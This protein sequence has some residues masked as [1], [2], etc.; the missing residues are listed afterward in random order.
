MCGLTDQNNMCKAATN[1]LHSGEVVG[2]FFLNTGFS[3]LNFSTI[4]MVSIFVASY[5]SDTSAFKV[6]KLYL[7][8]AHIIHNLS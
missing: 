2:Y 1:G 8:V 5:Q 3:Q 7:G 4:N 6:T